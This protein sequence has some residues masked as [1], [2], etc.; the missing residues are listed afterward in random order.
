M[1]PI[2]ALIG[3][4]GSGK[5]TVG[6]ALLD[7]LRERGP[8]ELCHL[9][10]QSGNLGRMIGRLP[11]VGRR[12]ESGLQA[13]AKQA[14]APRGPGPVAALV[15]YAFTLR[16]VRRFRRM[17]RHRDR[18]MTILADRFPQTALPGAIDGPG[19]G[20]LLV[21]RG[22]AR[23]LADRE[24]RQFAWMTSHRPDLVLRLNVDLATAIARKPDHLPELLA[25]KIANVARLTFAGAPIVDIDATRPIEQV[26]A[27]A[28]AAIT[29]VLGR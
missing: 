26:L 12:V 16:R 10:K 8:A 3:S 4:D 7:W 15:V 21:D 5:S 18:G 20:R 9:G 22:F 6:E 17:L 11:L 23:W 1:A 29:A 13:K 2:I 19:F 14:N 28:K 25:P 24:R 27:Q